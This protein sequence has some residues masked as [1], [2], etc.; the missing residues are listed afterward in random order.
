MT[1]SSSPMR[2][3]DQIPKCH[4]ICLAIYNRNQAKERNKRYPTQKITD[5]GYADD[6]AEDKAFLTNL[7]AQVESLT[8]SLERAEVGKAFVLT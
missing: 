7:P 3:L 1:V 5:P 2:S 8:F 4:W 6:K